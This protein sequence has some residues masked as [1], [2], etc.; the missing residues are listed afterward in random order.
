MRGYKARYFGLLAVL[1]ALPAFT[2][3]VRPV[4]LD[5]IERVDALEAET[6]LLR[7]RGRE[8]ADVLQEGLDALA[9]RV[10]V[11]EQVLFS[12]PVETIK[13]LGL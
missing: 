9:A 7:E 13:C 1:L 5:L 3:G 10:D 2:C 8:I 12:E 6:D 4:L 11:I